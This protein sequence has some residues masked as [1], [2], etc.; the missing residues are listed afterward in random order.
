[1]YQNLIQTKKTMQKKNKVLFELNNKLRVSLSFSYFSLNIFEKKTRK[2]LL[3]LIFPS[4]DKTSCRCFVGCFF[5][6][7]LSPFHTPSPLLFISISISISLSLAFNPC[8]LLCSSLLL[9][10]ISASAR[11]FHRDYTI[12]RHHYWVSVNQSD[13]TWFY[14]N[15]HPLTKIY[16]TNQ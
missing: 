13:K 11:A 14:A 4:D 8:R 6:L 16:Y 15:K 9:S 10:P 3:A 1:M 5:S 12:A 7:S 2:E